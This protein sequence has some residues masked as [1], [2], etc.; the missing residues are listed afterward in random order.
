[1]LLMLGCWYI[2]Q[3][4]VVIG[5][6]VGG[7]S[8]FSAHISEIP[9]ISHMLAPTQTTDF[10]RPPVDQIL[11][12]GILYVDVFLAP[13][14]NFRRPSINFLSVR[15]PRSRMPPARAGLLPRNP[16]RASVYASSRRSSSPSLSGGHNEWFFVWR[17]QPPQAGT[18]RRPPP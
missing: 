6:A 12:S 3:L 15:F 8:G 18:E 7:R 2:A 5:D 9:E 4:L 14:I 16:G 10:A 17:S 13:S 1:M 11:R